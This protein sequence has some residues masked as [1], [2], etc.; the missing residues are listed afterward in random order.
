MASAFDFYKAYSIK[1]AYAQKAGETLSLTS[2]ATN[3]LT[4]TAHGLVDNDVIVIITHATNSLVD[5]KR[6]YV[7]DATANNFKV[8]AT[9]G[10]SA[11]AIG[12]SGTATAIQL[13]N[14]ELDWANKITPA[15]ERDS[16][17]WAGSHQKTHIE[18]LARL[19]LTIDLDCIPTEVHAA[20][21]DK[22]TIT[23]T[24][25]GGMVAASAVGFG[26][27]VDVQGASVGML[28]EGY[29]LKGALETPVSFAIWYPAGILTLSAA[30]GL[31]TGA[32]ADK[33]QYLFSATRGSTDVAGGTISDLSDDGEFYIVA[34]T[35]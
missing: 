11:V 1:R 5:L 33:Q 30:P 18:L 9:K 20:L 27:G 28:L 32:V 23:D 14:Y 22:D 17:D 26:G 3:M 19:S 2:A 6:Y 29:A 16:Y 8:A 35:A 7:R 31:T 10:G 13:I 4:L 15:S 25:V 12:D 24:L 34:E 21:F